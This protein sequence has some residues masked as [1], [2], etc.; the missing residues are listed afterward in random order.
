MVLSQ[1]ANARRLALLSWMLVASFYFYLSYDYIR[2]TTNDSQFADYLRYVV[3]AAGNEGR[4]SR[5]VREL[6]LLKAEK[7]SL[8]VRGDQ[9]VVGGTNDS[10]NVSVKYDVD[11]EIP[12][13]QREFF[14]KKFEHKVS[15]QTYQ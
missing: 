15:Y 5:D 8:P 11:I 4:S 10:L 3:Q 2:V 14:T 13:L 9:I 1:T 6:V 7:L 12:L